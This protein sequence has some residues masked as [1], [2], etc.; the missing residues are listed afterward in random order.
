[1]LNYKFV[2]VSI[3]MLLITL[4]SASAV[5]FNNQTQWQYG[6]GSFKVTYTLAKDL[7]LDNLTIYDTGIIINNTD[8]I[9][10]VPT[11]GNLNITLYN[12]THTE[13][14]FSLFG[15]NQ[16]VAVDIKISGSSSVKFLLNDVQ[17]RT[18]FNA[19]DS[20]VYLEYY[21]DTTAPN[22]LSTATLTHPQNF[23]V[24]ITLDEIGNA[25]IYYSTNQNLLNPSSSSSSN[26]KTFHSFDILG[27]STITTYYYKINGSDLVGNVYSTN[28]LTTTTVLGGSQNAH[29]GGGSSIQDFSIADNDV[30]KPIQVINTIE[31]QTT[32][33]TFIF[34]AVFIAL[35]TIMGLTYLNK[36]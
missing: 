11:S 22:I 15:Q 25:N 21:I 19:T 18:S 9:S 26:Y 13:N 14:D 32:E 27:L 28:I 1:M 16:S 3:L 7:T 33:R 24:N 30:D 17:N 31:Q 12:W 20:S 34:G 29:T 8:N 10:F 5:T 4:F 23:S 2:F 6:N 36:K 35:I